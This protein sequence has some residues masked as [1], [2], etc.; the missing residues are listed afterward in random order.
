MTDAQHI[1]PLM[2]FTARAEAR[3]LLVYA[4]I[5]DPE[6]C[7]DPLLDD[8]FANGLLDQVGMGVLLAI[9]DQAFA[10][11]TEAVANGA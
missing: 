11:Y 9:I 3:A 4:A 6:I 10:P 7:F 2:V 8:A 1:T 5:Y